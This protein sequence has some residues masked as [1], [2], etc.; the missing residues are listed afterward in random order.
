MRSDI[1]KVGPGRAPHR[2]LLKG[3]GLIDEE[4]DR[5]FVAVVNSWN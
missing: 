4:M 1:T 2:A 5:P 3:T